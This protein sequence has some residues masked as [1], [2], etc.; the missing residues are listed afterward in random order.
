[1]DRLGGAHSRQLANYLRGDGRIDE[2]LHVFGWDIDLNNPPK[3]SLDLIYPAL[4]RIRSR[5]NTKHNQRNDRLSKDLDRIRIDGNPPLGQSVTSSWGPKRNHAKKHYL[6]K[7]ITLSTASSSYDYPS[8][9][10]MPLTA[11]FIPSQE[12]IREK[13]E[14]QHELSH[15]GSLT[16]FYPGRCYFVSDTENDPYG[17]DA[18]HH[19]PLTWAGAQLAEY[20]LGVA[21]YDLE[22]RTY[23]GSHLVIPVDEKM[24][25]LLPGKRKEIDIGELRKQNPSFQNIA[26]DEVL[27]VRRE[28]AAIYI[29][30][31]WT[32]NQK[33]CAAPIRFH[34]GKEYNTLL[35]RMRD[36]G[37]STRQ[38]RKR[39]NPRTN[40]NQ[41]RTQILIEGSDITIIRHKSSPPK[42]RRRRQSNRYEFYANYDYRYNDY[43][44]DGYGYDYG[45]G[46][47]GYGYGGYDYGYNSY[48]YGYDN[49]Q[50]EYGYGGYDYG[51]DSYNYG[52][53]NYQYEYGYEGYNYEY[54]YSDAR[55]PKR[56]RSDATVTIQIKP[57]GEIIINQSNTEKKVARRSK[58]RFSR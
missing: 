26:L 33:G 51:Y 5:K 21:L 52:Y 29:R 6:R 22:P 56:F 27:G 55:L 48:D 37:I 40:Q 45:Y 50:Y 43:G 47:Y 8:G 7:N 3:R 4:S 39:K 13:K 9:Q 44:Y 25:F 53:G 57:D 34:F 23:I 54:R 24:H 16:G 31:V 20:A 14:T 2:T 35:R 10:D 30:P 18:T 41:P 42:K 28:N 11:D 12:E 32:R 38:R 46:G 19:A 58:R 17:T 1:M 15:S 49:Y 36:A